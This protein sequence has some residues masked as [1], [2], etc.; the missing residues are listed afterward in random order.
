MSAYWV[1]WVVFLSFFVLFLVLVQ[2]FLY[3][4]ICILNKMYYIDV[5]LGLL[6]VLCVGCVCCVVVSGS[7]MGV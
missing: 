6:S 7:G 1:L 5:L 3:I 4:Y 2:V